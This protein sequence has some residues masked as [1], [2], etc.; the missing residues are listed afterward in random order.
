[1]TVWLTG[2]RKNAWRRNDSAI[3]MVTLHLGEWPFRWR[4]PTPTFLERQ[5]NGFRQGSFLMP[6]GK[7]NELVSGLVDGLLTV[8]MR[9][10][11]S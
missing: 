10:L 5:V 3:E 2:V 1:M 6:L 4:Q 11:Q 8:I 9:Y 7:A